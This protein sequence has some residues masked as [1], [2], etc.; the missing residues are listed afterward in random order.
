MK[1]VSSV[2]SASSGA[3]SSEIEGRV[4]T[5]TVTTREQFVRLS[6]LEESLREVE[7]ARKEKRR[8]LNSFQNCQLNLSLR[9]RSLYEVQSELERVRV[10][11]CEE[12]SANSASLIEVAAAESEVC[13]LEGEERELLPFFCE[14]EEGLDG[15]RR[16]QEAEVVRLKGV[17]ESTIQKTKEIDNRIKSIESRCQ[18]MNEEIT[19]K[20]VPRCIAT[21]ELRPRDLGINVAARNQQ[22]Q[23]DRQRVYQL[24][25]ELK[26]SKHGIVTVQARHEDALRRAKLLDGRMRFVGFLGHLGEDSDVHNVHA[27]IQ[28][29]ERSEAYLYRRMEEIRQE[30]STSRVRRDT[31]EQDVLE[32]EE[33]ESD[34][35]VEELVERIH[36]FRAKRNEWRE[37]T[38][39][40]E[41]EYHRLVHQHERETRIFNRV[42]IRVN[43]AIQQR[44]IKGDRPFPTS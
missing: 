24:H 4:K 11:L 22:R 19:R 43:D 7:V 30:L 41:A 16:G 37:Q 21:G 8:E 17:L 39:T 2:V 28:D 23:Q 38:E 10:Q 20:F 9:R 6:E 31:I 26:Q 44:L 5:L 18:E 33:D 15:I 13:R 1:Q 36:Q 25:S 12:E 40:R 32:E 27:E 34:F 42:R 29:L 3:N 35:T 14:F